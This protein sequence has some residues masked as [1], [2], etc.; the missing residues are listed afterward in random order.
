MSGINNALQCESLLQIKQTS[1]H[2]SSHNTSQAF[3]MSI[4]LTA[5]SFYDYSNVTEKTQL[6]PV[7]GILIYGLFRMLPLGQNT[8]LCLLG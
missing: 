8:Q 6:T 2:L 3:Q 1:A 5:E 7:G 4:I